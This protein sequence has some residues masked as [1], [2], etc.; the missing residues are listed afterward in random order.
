[1]PNDLYAHISILAKKHNLSR[2]KMTI[3]LLE[4]GYFKFLDLGNK[5][6]KLDK[7]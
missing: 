6:S 2:I 7:N 5:V 3:K 1:M 4:I